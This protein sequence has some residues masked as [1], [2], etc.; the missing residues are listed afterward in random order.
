MLGFDDPNIDK[1]ELLCLS[2]AIYHEARGEPREGKDAVA[3]VILN[4]VGHKWYKNSICGVVYQ[5]HQ[6]TNIKRAKPVDDK[7]WIK[8]VKAAI[9]A[10][11]GISSDPTHGAIMYYN[12]SKISK[13][14]WDFTKL[15]L[16][17]DIYNHR[18]YKQK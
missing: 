12:P 4:R 6:F 17:R 13:P 1:Q 2:T 8:S 7:Y 3:H 5:D 9:E 18:F 15:T 16:T 14:R 11:T 10:V